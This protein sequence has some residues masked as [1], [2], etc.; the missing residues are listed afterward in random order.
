MHCQNEIFHTSSYSFFRNKCVFP[1]KEAHV[2]MLKCFLAWIQ[3]AQ[4]ETKEMNWQEE[5]GFYMMHLVEMERRVLL[6]FRCDDRILNRI[7]AKQR[8]IMALKQVMWP[9]RT[10]YSTIIKVRKQRCTMNKRSTR[11][12]Y[13]LT[14]VSWWKKKSKNVWMNQTDMYSVLVWAQ[15]AYWNQV[16]IC[17]LH[18]LVLVF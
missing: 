17:Y 12:T 8:Y 18:K 7:W 11:L 3:S 13:A 10:I 2:R 9:V 4:R 5:I 14:R 15:W 1:R 16:V 6:F